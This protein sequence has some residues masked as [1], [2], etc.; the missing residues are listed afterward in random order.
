MK[1]SEITI[2]QLLLVIVIV[3]SVL[4]LLYLVKD[5][6]PK[7]FDLLTKEQNYQ[8][9]KQ[10]VNAK[11]CVIASSTNT[12]DKIFSGTEVRPYKVF[13]PRA[14][15]P[16]DLGDCDT[17]YIAGY[18]SQNQEAL[19]NI[20]KLYK[21][22]IDFNAVAG[23]DIASELVADKGYSAY[24]S[25]KVEKNPDCLKPY[26][27]D[28]GFWYRGSLRRVRCFDPPQMTIAN[29]PFVCYDGQHIIHFFT[30]N[31]ITNIDKG[32]KLLIDM[33]NYKW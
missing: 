7:T 19:D 3:T 31:D 22:V 9:V 25:G 26:C 30:I 17:I 11:I 16:E 28:Y 24:T 23:Y 18:D 33:L 10:N 12:I 27:F 29:Y 15:I 6:Y 2:F 8:N 21:S 4:T 13:N 14:V 20:I 1:K 5:T 32:K